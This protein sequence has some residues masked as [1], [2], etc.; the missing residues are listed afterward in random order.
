M[1]EI[2]ALVEKM[3]TSLDEFRAQYGARIDA[4]EKYIGRSILPGGGS[5]RRDALSAAAREHREKFLGWARKGGDTNALRE[6]EVRA[7][8]STLSD[9]DGGFLVPEEMEKTL[10][11]LAMDSLAMRRL[12]RIV[13][14]K[15]EYKKPLSA[16][17]AG[18]GWVAE[19]EERTETDTPELKLFAPAMAE[20]YALPEVTQ[21][22]LD[23][24]DFD[25]AAWL[26]E[27]IDTTLVEVEGESFITGNGVGRPKGIIDS[28]LMIANASWSYGK[29]GYIASGHAS[30][31]N[32][33][34]KLISL[35]H[36]LKPV[37]RRNATWLMND[38]TWEVL[39][40]FKD[41]DGN[42]MWR[43][44]LLEGAPDVFLGRPVEIDDNMPDIGEN[45]YPVA[46]ADFK[47]AYTIVDHVTG[48]RLL[49]DPYSH[50]G[51]VQFYVTKRVAAGISNYQAI[52]FLKVA[53][54]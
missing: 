13:T 9:P 6:L 45:A 48:L 11:R 54:S 16:G 4:I 31:V 43:P 42:Y 10:E 7:E 5:T 27:E 41:G 15:G 50:K 2:Q 44:G 26:T 52:K 36:A 12:A 40:K 37:Y 46:F 19:K 20:M 30:L 1:K 3:G 35:Q 53:A 34:D 21:K 28:A 39:R 38:N 14:S 47:R 24:S 29:T 17:G 51:W 18:G 49:R 23:M 25:V 33:L 32:N 8:L 22:L